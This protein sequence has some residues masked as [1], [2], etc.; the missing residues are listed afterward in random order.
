MGTLEGERTFLRRPLVVCLL[1]VFCCLL[2][3]SAFPCIKIGYALFEIDSQQTSSQILFAGIRF[4]LAGIMTV[5][6][7]SVSQRKIQFPSVRALPKV[8]LLSLFQ[9]VLQY[10]FFYVGLAHTT[11]VK[12]SIVNGA[13]TFLAILVAALCFRMEKL[14]AQK[15]IGC[16]V[17]FAGVVLVNLPQGGV[18]G[19]LALTGE[20]FILFSAISYAFSSAFM[21]RFSKQENPVMLSGWQFMLGGAVMIAVGLLCGGR[22]TVIS[23]GG[24]GMLCYLAFVSAAAYSI[25]SLLLKYNPVSRVAVYG[26]ANPVFGALLSVLLLSEAQT[27]RF[28][29]ETLAA[30][31]LVSAGIYVVNRQPK[32]EHAVKTP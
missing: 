5:I 4:F 9:T 2:W 10:L 19:G 21:K 11:G 3:G 15:L 8:A 17:G 29:W 28:G 26:F 13:G 23:A 1:A 14:S 31:I 22:L 12:A 32:N 7:G 16:A 6:V 30:L 27:S 20:G 24:I 25:W 18:S